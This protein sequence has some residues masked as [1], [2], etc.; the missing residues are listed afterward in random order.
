M[1]W[2][3]EPTRALLVCFVKLLTLLYTESHL[4]PGSSESL[5]PTR[6]YSQPPPEEDQRLLCVT[7]MYVCSTDKYDASRVERNPH[8]V[9]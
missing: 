2:P 7:C 1:C 8:L 5:C 6:S 4:P 3:H 9:S